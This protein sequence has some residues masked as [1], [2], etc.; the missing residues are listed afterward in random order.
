MT[1]IVLVEFT[2]EVIVQT[3]LLLLFA[4]FALFC[5]AVWPEDPK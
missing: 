5:V 1:E 4:A 3:R 2:E